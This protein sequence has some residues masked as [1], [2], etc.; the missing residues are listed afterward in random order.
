M[1]SYVIFLALTLLNQKLAFSG[2]ALIEKDYQNQVVIDAYQTLEHEIS[3]LM[4]RLF[5]RS[6]CPVK[7]TGQSSTSGCDDLFKRATES[8]IAVDPTGMSEFDNHKYTKGITQLEKSMGAKIS[9]LFKV[10]REQDE[11]LRRAVNKVF[12][13]TS[14]SEDEINLCLSRYLLYTSIMLYQPLPCMQS[15]NAYDVDL[16]H[17]S[18]AF[19]HIRKNFQELYQ[20][21]FYKDKEVEGNLVKILSKVK[22][23]TSSLITGSIVPASVAQKITSKLNSI[24][25]DNSM[26]RESRY[27]WEIQAF[28]NPGLNKIAICPQYILNSD[29]EFNLV[30][31]VAHEIAHSIDP[32][33]LFQNN[34]INP[35]LYRGPL[36]CMQQKGFILNGEENCDKNTYEGFCD[37][38]ASKVMPIYFSNSRHPNFTPLDFQNGY[39]N[40]IKNL[41]TKNDLNSEGTDHKDLHPSVQKRY[42]ILMQTPSIRR[43]MGCEDIQSESSCEL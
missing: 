39:A 38:I 28:Y 4:P 24:K 22:A 27:A 31:T 41:I 9:N 35:D 21:S 25:I 33:Q 43:Q 42:Q 14:M 16:I 18:E 19:N 20:D 17:R 15:S 11:E 1:K 2:A 23:I 30:H 36:K 10:A 29:S 12:R 40:S 13:S 37:F 6:K 7:P 5:M 34:G 8:S 32:C 3:S 26:C